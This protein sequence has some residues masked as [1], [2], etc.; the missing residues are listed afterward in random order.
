MTMRRL[1]LVVAA[2][3]V[4]VMAFGQP[5]TPEERGKRSDEIMGKMRTIELA[6]Q[7]LPLLLTKEQLREL[8]PVIEK[9]RQA[10]RAA[11]TE[12]FT[13][14]KSYEQKLDAALKEALDK[15]QV[16]GRE[17]IGE[18]NRLL[19]ALSLKRRVIADENTT[20]VM[21]IV[22]K[23]FNAGQKK[24]AASSLDPKLFDP[25]IKVEEMKESD[26][27]RFFIAEILLDP[28]GYDILVRLSR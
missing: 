4:A 8:L 14:M 2:L 16:P 28:L 26:K 12:E 10:V 17:L 6:N 24:V 9:A 1:T 23:S 18:L 11:Q 21:A 7:I 22:E 27:I 25:T 5:V 15:G 20:S 13:V 3:A 19:T